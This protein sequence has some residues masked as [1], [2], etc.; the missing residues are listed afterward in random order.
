MSD[1]FDALFEGLH[2]QRPPAPFAPAAAVRRRG[3]QRA[4]RQ[5]VSIGVAVFAV[6]G[7]GAGGI[8][9]ALGES[10]PPV[11]PA[12]PQVTESPTVTES[13]P[14]TE[15]PT[16]TESPAVSEVP[17]QWLL[18]AG[19]LPGA[20]WQEDTGELIQGAWYWDDAEPWC[21]EYAVEDYPS[22]ERK[23]DF[24]TGGWL[25]DG[26]AVPE[27][28]DQVVELYEPGTGAANVV[29]V[30]AYLETCSR[31]PEAGDQVAPTYYEIEQTGFAGDESLLIR[32]EEYQFGEGDEI[33]PPGEPLHVAV[34]RVGDAV[35]TIRFLNLP[36]DAVAVAQR[37]AD[38]L[39][40]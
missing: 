39:A 5:A 3:R 15:S 18:A 1:K 26:A 20:G 16:V 11:T 24:D 4:H 8:V 17:E 22:L 37:A 40:Q 36:D 33:E 25:R 27:R 19:D 9:A 35:T 14:V 12:S 31:R 29:D 28:V 7:L 21:P 2:G 13:P 38:R 10:D 30:Q 23:L 34:V 32:V 6:T